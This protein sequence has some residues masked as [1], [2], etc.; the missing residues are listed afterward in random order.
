MLEFGCQIPPK[1]CWNF[2]WDSVVSE[3]RM[4]RREDHTASNH[5]RVW[6]PHLCGPS[7]TTPPPGVSLLCR[8]WHLLASFPDTEQ[9]TLELFVSLTPRPA[10]LLRTYEVMFCMVSVKSY[11][12]LENVCFCTSLHCI[13]TILCLACLVNMVLKWLNRGFKCQTCMNLH[14][15]SLSLAFFVRPWSPGSLSLST[16][17]MPVGGLKSLNLLLGFVTVFCS[18][19]RQLTKESALHRRIH[20][21]KWGSLPEPFSEHSSPRALLL[22]VWRPWALCCEVSLVS[23]QSL[24]LNSWSSWWE[25][26]VTSYLAASLGAVSPGRHSPMCWW[27]G[28]L[29]FFSEAVHS[30]HR[31]GPSSAPATPSAGVEVW[32]FTRI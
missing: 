5:G 11:S 27:A 25:A 29:T 23:Y 13:L 31:K 9:Y 15:S 4:E 2:Y 24:S 16:L 12:I 30:A 6:S 32:A 17:E 10:S 1:I 3:G 28:S 8:D 18:D 7:L 21:W 22:V 20:S 19:W 14:P 26:S